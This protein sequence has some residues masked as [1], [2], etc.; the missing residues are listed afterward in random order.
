MAKA[1][2]FKPTKTA[3]QSGK[4]KT[5]CWKLEFARDAAMTPDAIM[6]WDTMNNTLTQIHLWFATK[7]EALA[8]ARTKKL[9]VEVIEPETAKVGPKS[10]AENFAFTRRQAFDKKA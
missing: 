10:Y 9:D 8:Y 7:E 4:A 3:M 5:K 2:I 6:G 1:K